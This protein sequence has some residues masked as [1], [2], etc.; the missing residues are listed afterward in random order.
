MT[1]NCPHC[2][3]EFDL[4]SVFRL[5]DSFTCKSCGGEIYF[6]IDEGKEGQTITLFRKPPGDTEMNSEQELLSICKQLLD[7]LG[8]GFLRSGGSETTSW[9]VCGT[10]GRSDWRDHSENCELNK[11][12]A[13][14]RRI[15][16]RGGTG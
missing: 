9:D 8:D 13:E 1:F 2:N 4:L 11:L 10:C 7:V 15:T 5:P 3:A 14:A 16:K 12:L 6:E